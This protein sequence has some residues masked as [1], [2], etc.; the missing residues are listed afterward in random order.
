MY[1]V[2]ALPGPYAGPYVC[3]RDC[4][5]V[6]QIKEFVPHVNQCTMMAV[7]KL[8]SIFMT[9]TMDVAQILRCLSYMVYPGMIT[10]YYKFFSHFDL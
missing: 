6:N 2:S 9:N 1:C 3:V 7:L 10:F 5:S 8:L 4:L